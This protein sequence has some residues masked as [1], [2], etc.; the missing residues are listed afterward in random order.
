VPFGHDFMNED[1]GYFRDFLLE[2][3]A[4]P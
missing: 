1:A 3:A 4:T 2:V